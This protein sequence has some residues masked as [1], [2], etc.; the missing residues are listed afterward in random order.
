MTFKPKT[1]IQQALA[2]MI[3]A[4]D[5][6][7]AVGAAGT[8][9][10]YVALAKAM[11]ALESGAVE[12]I[13]L[14]RPDAG[15]NATGFLPG[16]AADKLRSSLG[17][18]A[19]ALQDIAGAAL[20]ALLKDRHIRLETPSTL[21]GRSFTHAFVVFDD[22]HDVAE[23]EISAV[24]GRLG[25]GSKIIFCG[26]PGANNDSSIAKAAKAAANDAAIGVYN[27]PPPAPQAPAALAPFIGR[28]IGMVEEVT[29]LPGGG[30]AVQTRPQKPDDPLL[31]QIFTA[32]AA[33][34]RTARI[35]YPHRL[36]PPRRAA[37]DID[38]YIVQHEDGAWRTSLLREG[39]SKAPKPLPLVRMDA[40]E[41]A[42]ISAVVAGGAAKP[43]AALKPLRFKPR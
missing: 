13:V 26:D 9:K 5:I 34:G 23:A 37:D 24:A 17:P 6:S 38:I 19:A 30:H 8:G 14:C 27:I 28:D 43:I 33:A 25:L 2:D 7:F 42:G 16:S 20:P 12:T 41:L 39:M 3:D 18:Y 35:V 32:A 21:R 11:A 10:T 15:T 22:A 36:P 4:H 31:S 1:G 29:A 40:A